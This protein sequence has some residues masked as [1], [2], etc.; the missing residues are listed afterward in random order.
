MHV[1]FGIQQLASK[2]SGSVVTIGNFDGLHRGHREL[3]SQVRQ[4]ASESGLPAVV[5]TFDPHPLKILA[6]QK[7][8]KMI[9]PLTDR[10]EEIQKM[11]MEY[12]IIQ[13]FS[14][15]LSDLEPKKFFEDLLIDSLGVKRLIVGH[16]FSFGKDRKGDS[17]ML[18]QLC[19]ERA[20]AFQVVPPVKHDGVL[21]SSSSIREAILDGEVA[22]A[23]NL[24]GRSFY[25]RGVVEKGQGRGKKIGFPT[26]N[27]FTPSELFPKLGVYV[28]RAHLLGKIH[29]SVTN[30]G[31]NPTF[32]EKTRHPIQVET[33]IL[34]F[35]RDIYGEALKIEFLDFLR[36]EKK[37][38]SV[39][40]LV[41]QIT[42]DVENAERY[43][44]PKS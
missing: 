44:W 19:R 10:I 37:F 29:K 8:V 20:I 36:E 13:P 33:H 34:N 40:E 30:V 38:D 18:H 39:A 26:A 12:L 27:L 2:L 22:K 32:Q 17:E 6:P 42:H 7:N 15:E 25:L 24:L 28:T 3:I 11:G 21:V 43:S 16:D 41:K 4:A 14:R 31:R 9:F 23:A 35:D 1:L 5:M